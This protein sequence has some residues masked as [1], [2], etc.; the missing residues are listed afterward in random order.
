VLWFVIS[1][2]LNRIDLLEDTAF[3]AR[4]AQ[5]LASH[6]PPGAAD[7][8]DRGH[9]SAEDRRKRGG[10]G[11]GV[12]HMGNGLWVWADIGGVRELSS[13][14][15]L[16][17]IVVCQVSLTSCCVASDRVSASHRPLLSLPTTAGSIVGG[18]QV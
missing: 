11:D 4:L 6:P 13:L 3:V 8:E 2:S 5:S 1:L 17:E 10:T 9:G 18:G 12:A 16:L 15:R 7:G 14:V